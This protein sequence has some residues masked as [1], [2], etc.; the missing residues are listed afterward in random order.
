[1]AHLTTIPCGAHQLGQ[2]YD[3]RPEA[4]TLRVRYGYG[5]RQRRTFKRNYAEHLSE[6][7]RRVYLQSLARV[8]ANQQEFSEARAFEDRFNAL[9]RRWREETKTLSSTTDRALHPAYQDIIGMGD[10]V[11]PL[12]FRE[13]QERGGHW[14]WAFRHITHEN[15]VPPEDAGKIQQMTEAWLRW[16]REHRYL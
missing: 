11:L 14:F 4:A 5:E 10:R 3:D 12:L 16:G 9:V 6:R 7:R 15:P 2:W 8:L 13:M 1:M